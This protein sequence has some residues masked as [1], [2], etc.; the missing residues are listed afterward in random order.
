M[1]K[2]KKPKRIKITKIVIMRIKKVSQNNQIKVMMKRK[3]A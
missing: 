1:K 3:K 2:K